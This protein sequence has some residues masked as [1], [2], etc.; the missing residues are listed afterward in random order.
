MAR[1]DRYNEMINPPKLYNIEGYA[2]QEFDNLLHMWDFIKQNLDLNKNC[3]IKRQWRNSWANPSLKKPEEVVDMLVYGNDNATQ[4]FMELVNIP[5]ITTDSSS[6]VRMSIEGCGYDMGAVISGE[7]ECCVAMDSPN[8]KECVDIY[9]DIG[10]CGY[11]I[12]SAITH[13]GVAIY[14]LINT[15]LT[16]GN[17]VTIHMC[18]YA[19][20]GGY[21][22][23]IATVLT[24]P[25]SDLSISQIAF[26]SS[27]EYFRM[28]CWQLEEMMLGSYSCGGDCQSGTP[29]K[30]IAK[31]KQ[32]KGL[33]IP[34][35]YVDP[36]FDGV[37][38]QE[39]ADELVM[40]YYEKYIVDQ[41]RLREV[42]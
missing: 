5:E 29:E 26:V 21:N 27:V 19:D 1:E 35:G 28:L 25:T 33:F 13:R 24:L 34:G 31:I 7:P 10:Y 32:D 22:Q 12:A 15:L 18:R 37:N 39:R 30:V 23:Q 36:R 40:E 8:V 3:S 42:A 14:K 4:E 6:G 41:K 9:I 17:I 11:V 16:Q 2:V 20:Y 38:N